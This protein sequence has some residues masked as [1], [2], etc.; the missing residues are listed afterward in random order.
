M[1]RLHVC[2]A[3]HLLFLWLRIGTMIDPYTF[4]TESTTGGQIL[5]VYE[6]CNFEHVVL[7]LLD[8]IATFAV[9]FHEVRFGQNER[10][11]D[12]YFL[13]RACNSDV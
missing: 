5:V 7:S 11:R 2:L 4:E 10:F 9:I 8:I 12:V 6:K 13:R 3:M 1:R